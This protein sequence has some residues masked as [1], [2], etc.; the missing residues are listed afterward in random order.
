MVPVGSLRRQ[1]P[2]SD[3][4][5][6]RPEQKCRQMRMIGRLRF[7]FPRC[8]TRLVPLSVSRRRCLLRSVVMTFAACVTWLATGMTWLAGVAWLAAGL[9][10]LA[11]LAFA[12]RLA[13]AAA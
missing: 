13:A 10:L 11:R 12:L 3:S 6:D 1:S 4:G 7:C 5:A 8:A 2:A 9:L